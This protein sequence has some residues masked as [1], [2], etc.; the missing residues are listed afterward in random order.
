MPIITPF[1]LEVAIGADKSW[2]GEYI[3]DFGRLLEGDI[4]S[5]AQCRASLV[6]VS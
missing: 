3:L 4:G 6:T 2:A 5:G 1:E